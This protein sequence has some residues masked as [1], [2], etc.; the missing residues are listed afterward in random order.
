[1][2]PIKLRGSVL[3]AG[4]TNKIGKTSDQISQVTAVQKSSWT[5]I[6]H[7]N[8]QTKTQR[9]KDEM[10]IPQPKQAATRKRSQKLDPFEIKSRHRPCEGAPCWDGHIACLLFFPRAWPILLGGSVL[11]NIKINRETKC[12]NLYKARW[13]VK[14]Q[15]PMA[16]SRNALPLGQKRASTHA[17]PKNND[18]AK[19][20]KMGPGPTP[21]SPTTA[22]KDSHAQSSWRKETASRQALRPQWRLQQD[23]KFRV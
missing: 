13:R 12:L 8:Q 16:S 3:K 5:A 1:M 9:R 23:K 14:K 7:K 18:Q 21:R 11:L 15:G 6:P 10:Q 2:R 17:K 22:T 4:K 19:Q 20:Q